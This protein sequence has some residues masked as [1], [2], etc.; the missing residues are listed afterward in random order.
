MRNIQSCK[1]IL[2]LGKC[3]FK[4]CKFAHTREEVDVKLCILGDTCPKIRILPK[5][6]GLW[7][8]VSLEEVCI[9]KH[10]SETM[11]NFY[12]R[13]GWPAKREIST[14]INELT[15][16]FTNLVKT[17]FG[18]DFNK[19]VVNNLLENVS[20][21]FDDDNKDKKDDDDKDEILDIIKNNEY[22][23]KSFSKK[24][25]DESSLSYL[26]SIKMSQSDCIKL[27]VGIEKVLLEIILKKT[28]LKNIKEKNK[29]GVK[30]KDHLLCDEEGKKIYYCEIKTNLN[31]D[32]EKSKSTIE[33]CLQ[34][35]NKLSEEYKD[36]EIIWCLLGARYYSKKIM[37]SSILNKYLHIKDNVFGV[38]EYF[39]MLSLPF[40]FDEESYKKFIN[41]VAKNM[42][43]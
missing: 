16:N 43:E 15:Q 10:P 36:Y 41:N 24:T 20:K 2:K 4:N 18:P 8:V 31:L 39:D 29:K 17:S 13:I 33:K 26:V 34:I 19:Q 14:D 23:K 1:N 42:F 27:G 37:K 3:D 5:M 25:K 32:T 30:E 22:I 35:K 21:K 12:V 40:K 11:E 7:K 6:T 9:C 38:N 28:S